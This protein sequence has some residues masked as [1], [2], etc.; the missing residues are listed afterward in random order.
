MPKHFV[1]SGLLLTIIAL[2]GCGGGAHPYGAMHKAAQSELTPTALAHDHRLKAELRTALV[3][4][5]GFAGLTLSPEVFMERGYVTG[6]VDTSDQAE[7]VRR[8][9]RGVQGL[10]SVD[11]YLPVKPA[12]STDESS[13]TADLALKAE[14]AS[15]LK[16]A[17]GVVASRITTAV[18][19]GHVVLMG[20]VSDE[21][22]RRK[23]AEVVS[24]VT[25]VK[26]TTNWLLL[27]ESGYSTLRPKL[28]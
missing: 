24:G 5:Q 14:T 18:L 25:G 2:P 21:E 22:A 11:A 9:A 20:V 15:A 4:E 6:R 26:G 16:L 27:P 8:V 1:V 17:P 7:A 12:Q 3:S 10:R 23:A 19:D 28:R 13:L